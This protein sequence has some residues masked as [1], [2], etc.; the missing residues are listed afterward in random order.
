MGMPLGVKLMNAASREIVIHSLLPAMPF[1]RAVDVTAFFATLSAARSQAPLDWLLSM[2][3][4]GCALLASVTPIIWRR[5]S[6]LAAL[7][8]YVS[9]KIDFAE[10]HTLLR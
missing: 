4:T 7:L 6:L 2:L 3:S 8:G 9:N 5:P 10:I 1:T